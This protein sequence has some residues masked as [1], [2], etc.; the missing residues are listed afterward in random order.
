V[1]LSGDGQT[2]VSGGDDGTV[3]LWSVASGECR[4]VLE[5]H[6]AAVYGV[7][8]T[9]TGGLLASAGFD[10]TL[11]VWDAE[12]AR[13]VAV[14]ADHADAV[15]AVTFSADGSVA[16]S[17]SLDGSVKV[18]D[19]RNFALLSTLRPDRRYE[20]MNITGLN[21]VTP[22]QRATLRSLGAVDRQR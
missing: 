2:L 11:G 18:W 20:R 3:R 6:G 1:A 9:R 22:A 16:A 8:I 4:A 19:M 21:G 5:G 13:R 14:L 17:G 10:A 7:A 12:S 15:Y